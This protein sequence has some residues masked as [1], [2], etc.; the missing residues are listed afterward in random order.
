M[1]KHL[2]KTFQVQD[3]KEKYGTYNSR[4]IQRDQYQS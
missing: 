3:K 1:T 4:R 2:S